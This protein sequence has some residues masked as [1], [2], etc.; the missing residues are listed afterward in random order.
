MASA[1]KNSRF[2]A[3]IYRI[4]GTSI[5]ISGQNLFG[6]RPMLY[7]AIVAIGSLPSV[8]L[9]STLAVTIYKCMLLP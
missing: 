7:A 5:I 1:K 3:G 9:S 2:A 6:C 8:V 4:R